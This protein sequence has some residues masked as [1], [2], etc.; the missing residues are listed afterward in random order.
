MPTLLSLQDS[1]IL[2]LIWSDSLISQSHCSTRGRFLAT[3]SPSGVRRIFFGGEIHFP[4][5]WGGQEPILKNFDME[6]YGTSENLGRGHGPLGP[7]L[8]TL[9]LSPSRAIGTLLE[10]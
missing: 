10:D 3:L 9:V 5:F 2:P 1:P 8:R 7:S 6:S 4:S